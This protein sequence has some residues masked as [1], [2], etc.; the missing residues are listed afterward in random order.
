MS[1]NQLKTMQRLKTMQHA[2]LENV[3][4]AIESH[5][6]CARLYPLIELLDVFAEVAL[7]IKVVIK[8]MQIR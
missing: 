3:L 1:K 6:P 7:H 4:F 2:K 8:Q 5:C